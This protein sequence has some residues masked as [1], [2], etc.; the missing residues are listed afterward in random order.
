MEWVVLDWNQNAID[1]YKA[2]GGSER[3]RTWTMNLICFSFITGMSLQVIIGAL[4]DRETYRR[5]K[6]RASV[7]RLRGNPFLRRSVWRR[8]R[9]YNRADFHPDD[10][11]TEALL[12][13]WRE[14]LF[15]ADGTLNDR[16]LR[17]A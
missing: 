15:G 13:T 8:L 10:H 9:D 4:F 5:G 3:T 7:G 11:D 14:R 17:S 1:V 2:I 12:D 16:L 6:L